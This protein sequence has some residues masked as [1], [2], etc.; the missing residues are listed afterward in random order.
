MFL[1]RVIF[2]EIPMKNILQNEKLAVSTFTG[3]A[4]K[5]FL[6]YNDVFGDYGNQ[7]MHY[8]LEK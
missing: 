2:P 7:H 5:T 4:V 6:R 3:T 8:V 1:V